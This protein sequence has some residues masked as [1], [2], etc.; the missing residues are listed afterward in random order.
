MEGLSFRKGS[1]GDVWRVRK[2]CTFWELDTLSGKVVLSSRNR[3]RRKIHS[4]ALPRSL[5]VQG[6]GEDDYLIIDCPGQIELYSHVSVFKT[7][8]N[9]LKINGWN[10]CAVRTVCLCTRVG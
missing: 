9:Y 2:Q 6:F 7:L 5:H 10:V 1:T 4:A 3:P 8:T